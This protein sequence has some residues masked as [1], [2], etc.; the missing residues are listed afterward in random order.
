MLPLAWSTL[1]ALHSPCLGLV[2][3]FMIKIGPWVCTY[4]IVLN[5]P[6]YCVHVAVGFVLKRTVDLWSNLPSHKSSTISDKNSTWYN[7]LTT[8]LVKEGHVLAWVQNGM[9]GA[10][11]QDETVNMRSLA[12]DDQCKVTGLRR[13]SQ[14][15]HLLYTQVW[16][17]YSIHIEINPCCLNALKPCSVYAVNVCV[18]REE[19]RGSRPQENVIWGHPGEGRLT[20]NSQLGFSHTFVNGV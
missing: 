16:L 15:D 8:P 10:A 9:Q 2:W 3:I 18:K 19:S 5:C 12:A 20:S 17:L 13:L 6:D 1:C 4:C 7:L 14:P 11:G